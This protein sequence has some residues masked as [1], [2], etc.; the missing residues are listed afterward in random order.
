Q[1]G[2]RQAGG[3]ARGAGGQPFGVRHGVGCVGR[4]VVEREVTVVA[5]G[6]LTTCWPVHP[7][8]RGSRKLPLAAVAAACG[9]RRP[10][11]TWPRVLARRRSATCRT[12]SRPFA[13]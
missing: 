7:E 12:R 2:A 8:R 4:C 3:I 5:G 13:S 6:R 1:S 9:G 11:E 10:R